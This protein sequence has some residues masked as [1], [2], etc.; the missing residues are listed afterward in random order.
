[1]RITFVFLAIY[2]LLFLLSLA[3]P[4]TFVQLF[5]FNPKLFLYYPW[6]IITSLFLHVNFAHL[7]FNSITLLF[8]GLYFEQLYGKKH[9]LILYIF[10]GL[11][12]NLFFLLLNL[13]KFVYG[14]GASGSLFGIMAA[15]AIKKPYDQ[16]IMFPIIIPIPMILALFVWIIINFL[17]IIFPYGN[18]GYSAH[19]GG[20]LAGLLYSKY[21]SE[22]EIY[23]IKVDYM[24]E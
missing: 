10:A 7:F 15:L 6:T 21:L 19:L 4:D 1:M 3:D 5:A 23:S 13:D 9:F 24:I 17:G 18:I 20:I 8:F 22:E 16:V 11:V 12:G 2:I 14:L